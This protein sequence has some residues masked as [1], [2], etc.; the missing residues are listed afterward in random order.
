MAERKLEHQP[1]NPVMRCVNVFVHTEAT[2]QAF[3]EAGQMDLFEYLDDNPVIVG[4]EPLQHDTEVEGWGL[5]IREIC[6]EAFVKE[7]EE[8]DD[9]GFYHKILGADCTDLEVIS[10]WWDI[11][12]GH[13]VEVLCD[14]VRG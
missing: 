8:C 11:K 10:K 12:E 14:W 2:K 4:T 3:L 5:R 1:Q 13:Y 7:L 9:L 6:I